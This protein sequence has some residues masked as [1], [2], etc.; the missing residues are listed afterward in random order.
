MHYFLFK[1]NNFFFQDSYFSNKLKCLHTSLHKLQYSY[2]QWRINKKL[3]N[4]KEISPI[5]SHTNIYQLKSTLS[6]YGNRDWLEVGDTEGDE[7]GH[8]AVGWRPSL[9]L[10]E[11]FPHVW[12]SFLACQPTQL[13][14][15]WVQLHTR[16]RLKFNR[17]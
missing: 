2:K 14:L 5:S 3:K 17:E 8:R 10:C 4:T 12:V 13:K 11:H 15:Q 9:K 1:P 7:E 6:I 16:I